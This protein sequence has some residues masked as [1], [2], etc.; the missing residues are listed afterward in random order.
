MIIYNIIIYSE[1]DL[2]PLFLAYFFL[3]PF[4]ILKFSLSSFINFSKIFNFSSKS[5]AVESEFIDPSPSF[6]LL[7][8]FFHR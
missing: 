3:Y 2:R 8:S 4:L 5:S 6:D 7:S 1:Y